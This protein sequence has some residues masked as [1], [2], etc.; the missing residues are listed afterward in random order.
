MS[1]VN[2][3]SILSLTDVFDVEALATL[4]YVCKALNKCWIRYIR[5]FLRGNDYEGYI[6]DSYVY[7]NRKIIIID[8]IDVR[9]MCYKQNIYI[10]LT[11]DDRVTI[12]IFIGN[13]Y[14]ISY[15]SILRHHPHSHI[16]KNIII[17]LEK[18]GDDVSA[19]KRNYIGYNVD[20]Q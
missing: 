6:F 13:G 9:Q 17:A 7:K 15:N 14:P 12:N 3:S 2:L 16:T 18:R 8:I 10:G 19:L 20:P 11:N 1:I 5:R 4:R